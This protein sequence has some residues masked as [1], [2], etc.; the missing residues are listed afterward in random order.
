[1]YIYFRQANV[2][3]V[4][5]KLPVAKPEKEQIG[6]TITDDTFADNKPGPSGFPNQRNLFNPTEAIKGLKKPEESKQFETKPNDSLPKTNTDVAQST[7]NQDIP[8]EARTTES[9]NK[10]GQSE[11]VK[12]LADSCSS[13]SLE[14]QC[15]LER[16][17]TIEEEVTFVSS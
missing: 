12:N 10:L 6:T 7:N 11:P 4:Y 5:R 9:V 13:S 17:L 16:R 8:M 14:T 2:S 3:S 15:Q 1:M